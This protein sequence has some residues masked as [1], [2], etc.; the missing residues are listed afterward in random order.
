MITPTEIYVN[1]TKLVQDERYLF[2]NLTLCRYH[3]YIYTLTEYIDK[4]VEMG[5]SSITL[6]PLVLNI[7]LPKVFPA[8]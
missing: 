7:A 3:I 4:V 6:L 5:L 8:F 1:K 2:P